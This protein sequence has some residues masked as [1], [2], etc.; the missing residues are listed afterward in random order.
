MPGALS[1]AARLASQTGAQLAWIPRR[2][3]E[4]GAIEAG[5]L[6]NLLPGGR[7]IGSAEVTAEVARVWGVGS[8]PS[9]PGCS[10]SE[11]L[12]AAAAGDIGALLIGASIRTTCP[13]RLRR[14]RRSKR[15]VSW[16]ASSCASAP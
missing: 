11:I 6:P 15:P 3:G 2:A 12:A 8:L 5:A 13:T 9:D 4:R 1:A 7:R 16:S 10:T 14:W